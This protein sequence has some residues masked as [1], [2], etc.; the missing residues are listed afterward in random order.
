MAVEEACPTLPTEQ[1]ITITTGYVQLRTIVCAITSP[2]RLSLVMLE[3]LAS[4][5]CAIH[6]AGME[7][8]L[9]KMNLAQLV[10]N[11]LFSKNDVI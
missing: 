6:S 5:F 4:R 1:S 10:F 7:N 8:A 3:A 9:S 2:T 11:V